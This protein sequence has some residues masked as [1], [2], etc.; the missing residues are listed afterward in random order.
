MGEKTIPVLM[1]TG[2]EFAGEI[3]ELVSNVTDLQLGDIVSGEG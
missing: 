1:T 2:H 3:V